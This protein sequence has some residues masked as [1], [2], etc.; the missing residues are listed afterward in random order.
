MSS[1]TSTK[2]RVEAGL[3]DPKETSAQAVVPPRR[4]WWLAGGFGVWCSALVM[5]YA[6]H[7]I[8]CTFAWQSNTL[9]LSLVAVFLTHLV[10]IGWMWG[11]FLFNTDQEPGPTSNFLHSAILWTVI[12]AFAATVLTLGLPLLLNTCV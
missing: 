10:V 12:T 3:D 9:R 2:T 6:L 5:L 4:V 1:S 7:A 11:H 8:G